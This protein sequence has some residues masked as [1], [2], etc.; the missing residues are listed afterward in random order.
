MRELDELLLRYLE[1]YYPDDS[2]T[3]KAAFRS[4]L[5]LSDPELNAYLLQRQMPS[6]EPIARVINRILRRDHS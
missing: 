6:S 2:D 4:V 5:D 3:D 1:D